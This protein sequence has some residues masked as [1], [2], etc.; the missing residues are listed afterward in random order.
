MQSNRTDLRPCARW[1]HPRGT[2]TCRD[3]ASTNISSSLLPTKITGPRETRNVCECNIARTF[4]VGRQWSRFRRRRRSPARRARRRGR[5]GRIPRLRQSSSYRSFGVYTESTGRD[6]R[7]DNTCPSRCC[8]VVAISAM[9]RAQEGVIAT[10][11]T[12]FSPWLHARTR[13]G[14]LAEDYYWNDGTLWAL[15]LLLLAKAA[16]HWNVA[17]RSA[18]SSLCAPRAPSL[19]SIRPGSKVEALEVHQG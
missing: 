18:A 7:C 13:P 10:I 2:A 3:V 1:Q 9:G 17:E 11:R 16:R 5:E 6:G 15:L 14:T 4:C 12:C 8:P 19:R